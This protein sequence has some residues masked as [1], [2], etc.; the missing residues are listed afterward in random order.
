MNNPKTQFGWESA[1][2]VLAHRYIIPAILSLLPTDRPLNILDAGCGNGYLAHHLTQLG[3]TVT[4]VDQAEDGIA[5]AQKTYPQITFKLS[6]IYDDL[7]SIVQNVDVV[8]S[9][10][11]IEHLYSP[12]IF[13][14]NMHSLLRPNGYIILTTPY[15]GYLK[16]LAL[17]VFNAWDKHHTVEAEGGHIKFF[18]EKTLSRMLA[19]S[20]F[21]QI[22]YRNAGRL[23]LLWKSM[24]CRATKHD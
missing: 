15:H 3:H 19:Q 17:S 2:P 6:S 21:Q 4:G 11:V 13:L 1:N 10:E 16:N 7:S 20:G 24:V 22:I 8:V 23:P 14:E 9:S 12:K 18:S 5:I